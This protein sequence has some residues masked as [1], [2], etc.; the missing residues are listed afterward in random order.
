MDGGHMFVGRE[1]ELRSLEG[2]YARAAQG[3]QM[4]VVYGRRRVGKTALLQRFSAGKP[5]LFFA[6]Q[7]Q[8]DVDNLRDFTR[9]VAGH[10]D[11]PQTMPPFPTWED[12]FEFLAKRAAGEHLVFVFD[13]FP[14]AAEANPVLPSALQIA[15]DHSFLQ[16]DCLMIL[17][18][19]NQ[20]FMEG[21]VLGEKSPLYG[22]RT[23]QL[24]L[25]P[26]DYLDAARML[27]DCTPQERV[28]YYAAFG[29][30]PYYLG[31]LDGSATFEQNVSRL[32]FEG[33]GLMYGEPTMLLRQELRDPSTYSSVLRAIAGGATRANTI[34]DQA[35]VQTSSITAYLRNLCE[36]GIVE[37]VV[38]HGE[39]VRSKKSIY[40]V[41]DP[42][43]A[44]WFR[45][46][47]PF[48]TAV[49][50]GLGGQVATRVLVDQR[51]ADYEGHIFERVC[52]QWVVRQAQAGTLP[53]M[54]TT[55]DS[56]WG[57]DPVARET[58]D[59]DVVAADDFGKKD[60]LVGE[61]KWR[62]SFDESDALKTLQRRAP[63]VGDYERRWYYVFSK[64]PVGKASRRKA[65][66]ATDVRFVSAADL[67]DA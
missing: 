19:S 33:T 60:V 40:R 10:Y 16:T 39:A 58:C 9:V 48:A 5:T 35:H 27:P 45:F 64:W 54:V 57:T 36:L 8:A 67:Y 7:Q 20:G 13:E 44:F 17:C 59:V 14:Y 23:A 15:I 47:A 24:K 66:A 25:Q 38:P 26:F 43:F 12:A 55:V 1:A 56:W 18:G 41:A 3:F 28:S 37:R 61:C 32:F 4:L 30:T 31:A 6:A 22:R 46:V 53:L 51:R 21:K 63:L 29:G 11:L 50:A 42:A 62:E 34:A 65:G 2:L 49:E 52:Q